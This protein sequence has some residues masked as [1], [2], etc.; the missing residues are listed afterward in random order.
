MGVGAPKNTAY[1]LTTYEFDVDYMAEDFEIEPDGI[2]LFTKLLKE[3][4]EQSIAKPRN[5]RHFGTI[6]GGRNSASGGRTTKD[7][8][9]L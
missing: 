5:P 9:S 7:T 2:E 8:Q 1:E 3:S 6:E 4:A